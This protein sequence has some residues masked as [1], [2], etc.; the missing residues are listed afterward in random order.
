MEKELKQK[1]KLLH[2]KLEEMEKQNRTIT[3]LN[4]REK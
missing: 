1:I 4:K 3:P 2:A